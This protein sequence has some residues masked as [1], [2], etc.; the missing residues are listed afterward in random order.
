MTD[1]DTSPLRRH[2]VHSIQPVLQVADVAAS[3]AFWTAKL[4]FG[5]DFA[6]GDPPDVARVF[7]NFD[8]RDGDA[9][10]VLFHR[11]EDPLRASAEL[12]IHVGRDVDGL[13]AAF[14]ARGVAIASP[15]ANEPW[16]LREF[17]LIDPDGHVLHFCAEIVAESDTST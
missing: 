15:P 7:N 6:L 2:E 17:T 10:F 5:L 12:R 11:A 4:G 13:C 16:G 14:H 3:L 9:A 1:D 8:R